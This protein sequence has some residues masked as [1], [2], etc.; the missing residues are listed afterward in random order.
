MN[1]YRPLVFFMLSIGFLPAFGQLEAVVTELYFDSSTDAFD[2]GNALGY[3]AGYKTYRIYAEFETPNDNYITGVFAG[4]GAE[5]LLTSTTDEIWNSPFGATTG[6][7]IIDAF[8]VPFP[9][10]EYDSFV[11]IGRRPSAGGDGLTGAVVAVSS[12]PQGQVFDDA[13]GMESSSGLWLEEGAWFTDNNESAAM[14]QGPDHR[15]LLAQVTCSGEPIY[16]LNIEMFWGDFITTGTHLWNPDDVVGE[17]DIYCP[18]CSNWDYTNSCLDVDADNYNP[19]ALYDVYC[20]YSSEVETCISLGDLSGDGV[21]N[22][23][24]VLFV[25]GEYG[26]SGDCQGDVDMDGS[27]GVG[28]ILTVVGNY[29]MNCD[30]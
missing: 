2:P 1:M 10:L 23:S 21:I 20:V 13:F 9:Y 3:P 25:V 8:L 27:V 17:N 4:G 16:N 26:C 19:D 15:V 11:T 29:G 24:D 12:M 18:T 7:A 5:L 30:G 6:D 22:A 28:D 14:P